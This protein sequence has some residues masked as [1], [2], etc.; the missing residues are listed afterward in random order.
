MTCHPGRRAAFSNACGCLPPHRRRGLAPLELTLTLP[1][2]VIMMALMINFG[3]VGAWKVRTQVN[4]RYSAWRTVNARTGEYNPIPPYWPANSPLKTQAGLDLPM[5]SQLWDAQPDLMCP[6]VRGPALTAPSSQTAINVPGRLEMDGFVLQGNAQ[7][8]KPLP[9]LPSA[10]PGSG[11]FQFN[12]K[13]DI[14]DNQWQFYSLRIPYNDY[15]RAQVWWSIQ[16]SSIAALDSAV[17]AS[18]QILDQN[19]QLLEGNP[20]VA[21]LFPLD[22]DDEFTRHNGWPPPDFYPRLRGLCESDPNIVY[23]KL[24]A[25]TDQNG[26]PNPNSLL[27]RIDKLPCTMSGSF[28]SLYR[29]WIC[30]LEKCGSGEIEPLRQRFSDLSQF[31]GTVA[32]CSTP[33]PLQPCMCPPKTTCACP[34]SPAGVGR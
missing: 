34:P 29:Q 10:I 27:S 9:L 20:Q 12:L 6:C 11:R 22:N 18:K 7:L 14:F 24:V 2:L 15:I 28:T 19:L 31:M 32:G 25:R 30:E 21:D 17:T 3:V 1:I 33:G 8:S 26:K 13:Q 4:T 5:V 16:H 23:T